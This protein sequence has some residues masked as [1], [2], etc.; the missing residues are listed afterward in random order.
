MSVALHPTRP[1]ELETLA[2]WLSDPE[3]NRWLTSEWRGQQIDARKMAI[4]VRNKANRLFTI[5][6]Q[7]RAVGLAALYG[8]DLT[9]G[10]A[11]IW[12]VLGDRSLGG[13]GITTAAVQALVTR[14]REELGLV[15]ITAW[16]VAPNLGSVRVLEKSGF[17]QVGRLTRST[18]VDGVR[19]DELLFENV[20]PE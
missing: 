10:Y 3:L 15:S 2:G 4:T 14:G 6:W 9:D 13:R 5:T 12:Y 19:Y 20:A 16:V 7:G 18:C 8:I 11:E 1:D 17:S